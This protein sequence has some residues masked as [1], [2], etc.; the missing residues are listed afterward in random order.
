MIDRD[1]VEFCQRD[2]IEFVGNGKSAFAYVLQFEVGFDLVLFEVIFFFAELLGIIPPVP[3]FQLLAFAF[4]VHQLLEFGSF[5]LGFRQGIIP[6]VVQEL[7][8]SGRILCHRIVQYEVGIAVE[9]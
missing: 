8:Y 3:G 1:I 6:Q 9:A 5:G 4:F 7:H 2:A